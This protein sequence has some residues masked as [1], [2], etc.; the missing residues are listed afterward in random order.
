LALSPSSPFF[1]NSLNVSIE[2]GVG[3]D[4][5][6][7]LDGTEPGPASQLYAGPI[8]ITS[9]TL[10]RARGFSGGIAFGSEVA[11]SYQRIYA[12]DDGIS[13]TWRIRHFGAGYLT[14][15][16]VAAEADPDGDGAS[17]LQ[18]FV[19]GT[20]PL[21]PLSGQVLQIRPAIS[22]SWNAVPGRRY[23][24]IHK[25][26]LSTP[27]WTTIRETTAS[28]STLKVIIEAPEPLDGF[29]AISAVQ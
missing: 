6:F 26:R 23:R 4:V 24:L 22:L 29:Y 15:P 5:R 2:G 7:T 21:D 3:S 12:V 20:D 28:Q 9:A 19:G 16:R 8:R 1:T 25:D 17:N 13:V 27:N 18:E 11:A 10:V 14:D